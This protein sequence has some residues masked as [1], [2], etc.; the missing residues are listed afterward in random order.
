MA[1]VNLFR[2]LYIHHQHQQTMQAALCVIVFARSLCAHFEQKAAKGYITRKKSRDLDGM[3]KML[4]QGLSNN[5]SYNIN[6]EMCGY[7]CV[8]DVCTGVESSTVKTHISSKFYILPILSCFQRTSLMGR[9][10][11]LIHI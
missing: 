2:Y 11:K 5:A 3:V 10:F 4:D 9:A 6:Q 7:V 1:G 8:G